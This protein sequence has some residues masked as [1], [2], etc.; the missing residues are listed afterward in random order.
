MMN[1]STNEED[2]VMTTPYTKKIQ[3]KFQQAKSFLESNGFSTSKEGI[4][5]DIL[6]AEEYMQSKDLWIVS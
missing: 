4:L 6:S 1:Y 5:N 2:Y 3:K